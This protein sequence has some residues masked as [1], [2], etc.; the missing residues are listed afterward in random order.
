[1][2]EVIR[3]C[4]YEEFLDLYDIMPNGDIYAKSRVVMTVTGP[5]RYKRRKL[6]LEQT[7]DGY[8][9]VVLSNAGR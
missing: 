4:K 2:K 1:M 7:K 9:R 8:L 3:M 6:K 5:R